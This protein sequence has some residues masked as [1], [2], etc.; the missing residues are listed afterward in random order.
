MYR[1]CGTPFLV[2]DHNI[3][4]AT[5]MWCW[6]VESAVKVLQSATLFD[7]VWFSFRI[8]STIESFESTGAR[9]KKFLQNFWCPGHE[10]CRKSR[11]VRFVITS[12]AHVTRQSVPG[13]G[14][15]SCFRRV[16]CCHSSETCTFTLNSQSLHNIPNGS[17]SS[18][19]NFLWIRGEYY[20]AEMVNH[21][22]RLLFSEKW[23]KY[24]QQEDNPNMTVTNHQ[25][26]LST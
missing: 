25:I 4:I 1:D 10:D 23:F 21:I 26:S 18:C 3:C 16:E 9:L 7:S 5:W 11:L 13:Y 12:G 2:S 20:T 8:W 19:C 22:A 17:S 15:F 6:M 14:V 24:Q